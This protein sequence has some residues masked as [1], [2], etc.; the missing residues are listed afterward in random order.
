MNQLKFISIEGRWEKPSV[1]FQYTPESVK[2]VLGGFCDG[3]ITLDEDDV[4]N[5]GRLRN[6]DALNGIPSC[7][8]SG[9]F[10]TVILAL[11]M[12]WAAAA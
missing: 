10:Q 2:L 6:D 4:E 8:K 1:K 9:E 12:S 5:R 7:C 11:G 3:V